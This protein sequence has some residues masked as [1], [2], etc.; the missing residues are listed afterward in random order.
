MG[1]ALI[2]GSGSYREIVKNASGAVVWDAVTS[3]AGGG[4]G[5]GVASLNGQTGAVNIVG[6]SGISVSA[7]GGNIT[8]TAA[9][10]ASVSQAATIANLRSLTSAS[11]P[12][13]VVQNYSTL[14][15][16]GGG[17]FTYNSADTTTTD[18]NCTI[19]VDS[20]SHRWYRQTGAAPLDVR[21]CGAKGNGTTDDTT[22]LQSAVAVGPVVYAPAGN[23]KITG[24]LTLKPSESLIG[25]GLNTTSITAVKNGTPYP[26]IT[27]TAVTTSPSSLGPCD[28]TMNYVYSLCNISVSGLTL[29]TSG[30]TPVAGDDGISFTQYTNNSYITDMYIKDQWNGL[31]LGPADASFVNNVVSTTNYG[32]GLDISNSTYAGLQWNLDTVFLTGNEGDGLFSHVNVGAGFVGLYVFG[33]P[34]QALTQVTLGT[35]T[36]INT[37]GNKIHGI[38]A[39]GNSSGPVPEQGVRIIRG[40]IGQDGS[41]EIYLDTYNTGGGAATIEPNFIELAGTSPTGRTGSNA[42]TGQGAGIYT[43]ASTGPVIVRAGSIKQNSHDGITSNG[44]SLIIDGGLITDNGVYAGASTMVNGHSYTIQVTGSTNFTSFGSSSNAVG[45]VFTKTGGTGTGTGLVSTTGR[46]NGIFINGGGS[47]GIA[48]N[49]VQ[50]GNT[51]GNTTQL[52]GVASNVDYIA[53]S[54]SNLL[55][56]TTAPVTGT[57]LANSVTAGSLPVAINTGGGGSGPYCALSGCI[58]TGDINLNGHNL[59]GA[60]AI[61]ASSDIQT[62]GGTI[63]A[64][65]GGI[66]GRDIVANRSMAVGTSADTV[67]GDLTVLTSVGIGAAPSGSAGQLAVAGAQII[68]TPTGSYQ[69]GSLNVDTAVKVNNVGIAIGSFCAL[70]GCTMTGPL[71]VNSS[72]QVDRLGIGAAPDATTAHITG[73]GGGLAFAGG[74]NVN[75]TGSQTTTGTVQANTGFYGN[76]TATISGITTLTASGQVQGQDLY[77]TRS[78]GVQTSPSGTAGRLDAAALSFFP[79]GIN[80]G[81]ASS[82]G[83]AFH[84]GVTIADGGMAFTTAVAGNGLTVDNISAVK[85]VGIGVSPSGTTGQLAVSSAEIIGSPTGSYQAN[86]LNV[87]GSLLVNNVGTAVGSFCALSG[88]TMTGDIAMGSHNISG[89]ADIA[90]T[91]LHVSGASSLHGTTISSGGLAVTGGVNS[92][93]EA[94]SVSL[95]VGTTASG[96]TGRINNTTLVSSGAIS[97][98]TGTFSS[99]ISG[100]TG[101]F[102]GNITGSLDLAVATLHVSGASA[103]HGTTV[104]SGG[105]AVTGGINADNETISVSLG[106]G[107]TASGVTGNIDATSSGTQSF[108]VVVGNTLI[109]NSQIRVGGASGL[110]SGTINVATGVYLNGTAYTNP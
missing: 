13:I 52:Y 19:F 43:T 29:D 11:V 15:D 104:V 32:H 101:T 96:V 17:V 89:A 16:F 41:D 57:A 79:Q 31:T 65:A 108:N 14:G 98:T 80:A 38:A 81:T 18:N 88:C 9:G 69:S 50:A 34:P 7:S 90:M 6:G 22:A 28:A 45:T 68:G 66:V 1:S 61:G 75:F 56:N 97:G 83:S 40:F 84:G 62:T 107:T 30:A 77:A 76:N 4:S 63:Y 102:T 48:I 54:G 27:T 82:F 33:G 2:W 87:A 99:A 37:F 105:V 95:G 58:M 106:V 46:S 103:I 67:T 85:S 53:I 39:V 25:D 20:G 5:S 42:A 10:G 3:S 59:S 60:L 23:Y 51:S 70:T 94:I 86:S 49:G 74:V 110:G 93:N 100:T 72:A 55:N 44:S 24:S 78:L 12:V 109:A 8:L 73:P 64:N 26:I 91:T 36:N 71:V 21:W 47:A 35:W 92:D